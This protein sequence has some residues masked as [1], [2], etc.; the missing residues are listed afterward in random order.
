MLMAVIQHPQDDTDGQWMTLRDLSELLKQ[1][2]KGYREEVGTFRRI[3]RIL[4]RPEYPFKS[5]RR[6]EGVIYWVK[7]RTP[8]STEIHK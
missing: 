8:R 3:G 6:K 1:T 4:A 7:P 2:F 5:Q